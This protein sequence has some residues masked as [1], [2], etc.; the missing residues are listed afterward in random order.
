M[1]A[2]ILYSN[3][4]KQAICNAIVGAS[5]RDIDKA[6]NALLSNK[7]LTRDQ[8]ELEE[9]ERDVPEKFGHEPE[10]LKKKR[11]QVN[12]ME[13]LLDTDEVNRL[14]QDSEVSKADEKHERFSHAEYA[15]YSEEET[16]RLIN[17]ESF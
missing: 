17:N 6:L 10:I 7:R 4:D 1:A 3:E 5:F 12:R 13:Y 15:T 16:L 11:K 2:K 14:L 8:I 9:L